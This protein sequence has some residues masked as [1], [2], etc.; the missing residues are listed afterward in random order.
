MKLTLLRYVPIISILTFGVSCAQ[1]SQNISSACNTIHHNVKFVSL[2][3]NGLEKTVIKIDGIDRYFTID[4][5]TSN[6]ITNKFKYISN[7]TDYTSYKGILSGKI[8]CDLNAQKN[9]LIYKLDD[10]M[11]IVDKESVNINNDFELNLN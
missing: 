9:I 6:I 2:T 10:I 1:R 3:F 4:S 11:E 8:T 7:Y 5:H